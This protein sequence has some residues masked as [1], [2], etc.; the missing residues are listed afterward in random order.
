MF[1]EPFRYSDGL[2][3]LGTI[4]SGAEALR[5]AGPLRARIRLSED[6]GR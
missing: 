3:R 5:R 4:D 6:E 1:Y 2:V